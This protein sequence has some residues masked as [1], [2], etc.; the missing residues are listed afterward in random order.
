[1]SRR[2]KR[3]KEGGT[4]RL[5]KI[6]ERPSIRIYSV[7]LC[8]F[9]SIWDGD[10]DPAANNFNDAR[11]TDSISRI[12]S[13]PQLSTRFERHIPSLFC[14]NRGHDG[15]TTPFI[16]DREYNYTEIE[17][18]DY[19]SSPCAA[20]QER[21]IL[22]KPKRK[23]FPRR[24]RAATPE[25]KPKAKPVLHPANDSVDSKFS[26]ETLGGW[27]VEAEFWLGGR[28][29]EASKQSAETI[30]QPENET[31]DFR[32]SK[33]TLS[34]WPAEA[35][36]WLGGRFLETASETT[37]CTR[38]MLKRGLKAIFDLDESAQEAYRAI[39]MPCSEQN[40]YYGNRKH[41]AEVVKGLYEYLEKM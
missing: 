23:P 32:N 16:H 9:P 13:S 22:P 31:V 15:F 28:F 5:R 17:D 19:I 4:R 29:L 30:F 14:R 11:L 39:T 26:E 20:A 1:M 38:S 40:Q 35:G 18:S 24:P 33:E 7:S 2:L 41:F 6:S 3:P 27:P 10:R 34:D 8:D 37:K 25:N 36:S 21:R 12:P